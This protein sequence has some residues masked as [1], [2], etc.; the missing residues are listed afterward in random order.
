MVVGKANNA[1]AIVSNN[2]LTIN[3][4]I[5]GNR[6][7]LGFKFF[8]KNAGPTVKYYYGLRGDDHTKEH[9]WIGYNGAATIKEFDKV[10]DFTAEYK[11]PSNAIML[12][13][14]IYDDCD[15]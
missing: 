5:T 12:Q 7:K 3:D 13:H 14:D 6:Q 15:K 8:Y 11:N 9:T 1:A 10:A 2:K 4:L